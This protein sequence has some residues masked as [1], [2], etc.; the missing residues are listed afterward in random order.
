MG[1]RFTPPSNTPFPE[2]LKATKVLDIDYVF[3]HAESTGGSL[4]VVGKDPGLFDYFLPERW[5]HTPREQMSQV[6]ETFKT[7]SK[8]DVHLVW[9][10]SSVGEVFRI[11]RNKT[12]NNHTGYNSPFEEFAIAHELCEKDVPCV[13]PRAIYMAGLESPQASDYVSDNSRYES[14]Q[15]QRTPEGEPVLRP[16]HNYITVW[17][18]WRKVTA[19]SNGTGQ[20]SSEGLNLQRAAERGLI[21]QSMV[22]ELIQLTHKRLKEAGF[23]ADFLK[24]SHL[25]ISIRPDLTLVGGSNGLPSVTLCNFELIQRV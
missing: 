8:D 23:K 14:H 18:Y 6:R 5:R 17:G 20:I 16:D 2:H 24:A 4:W 3:G 11:P 25:L 22:E 7:V 12:I 9:K 10:V 19:E 15:E 1:H 13:Y 21:P